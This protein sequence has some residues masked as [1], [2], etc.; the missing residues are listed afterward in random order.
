MHPA[1]SNAE[2]GTTGLSATITVGRGTEGPGC[3]N[4]NGMGGHPS[5]SV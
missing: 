3:P 4:K 2:N 5:F 1:Q